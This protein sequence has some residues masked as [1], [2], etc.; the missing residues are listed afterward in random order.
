MQI[1]N[2]LTKTPVRKACQIALSTPLFVD[3]RD[4]PELIP[5][6]GRRNSESR[7]ETESWRRSRVVEARKSKPRETV[8]PTRDVH[9]CWEV[10]RRRRR[11][12]LPPLGGASTFIFNRIAKLKVDSDR[13]LVFKARHVRINTAWFQQPPAVARV[14][15]CGRGRVRAVPA[16]E[17]ERQ[18]RFSCGVDVNR[19]T[20]LSGPQNAANA[21]AAMRWAS[22]THCKQATKPTLDC[23]SSTS[24]WPRF[25]KWIKLPKLKPTPVNVLK[26]YADLRW[27]DVHS[28][29]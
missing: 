22:P 28:F 20:R 16:R 10:R 23:D 26:A 14:R 19:R 6:A 4:A 1:S 8:K 18:G 11:F 12:Q 3:R 5:R 15:G 25:L 9:P 7:S 17:R 2:I 21:N 27:D 24:C 29:H 13:P